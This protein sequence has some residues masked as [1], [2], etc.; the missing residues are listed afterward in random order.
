[1]TDERAG[2]G[3]NNGHRLHS[4]AAAADGFLDE[5]GAA[6]DNQRSETEK[7]RGEEED[8]C[9]PSVFANGIG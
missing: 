2:A 6:G 5:G 8:P 4:A 3:N 9:R 1:M 7:G